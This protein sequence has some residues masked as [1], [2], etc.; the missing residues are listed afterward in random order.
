MQEEDGYSLVRR[1]RARQGVAQRRIP[2]VAVTA[3]GRAEDRA[4][5]MAAGFDRHVVKPVDIADLVTIVAALGR[6]ATGA[7]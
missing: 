2:A 6:P 1:I 3:Y 7:V 4:R 5:T